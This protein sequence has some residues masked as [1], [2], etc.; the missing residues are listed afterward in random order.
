ML[1]S[2]SRFVVNSRHKLRG[3]GWQRIWGRGE[4]AMHNP[5]LSHLFR[6]WADG[7]CIVEDRV[8]VAFACR[9]ENIGYVLSDW[10][11]GLVLLVVLDERT[12]RH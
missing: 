2:S 1:V 8:F 9:Q 3:A 6:I 10:R 7:V 5:A 4:D 11:R 12:A